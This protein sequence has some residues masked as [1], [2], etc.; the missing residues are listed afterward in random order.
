MESFKSPLHQ[1]VAT[2][3]TD[4]WNDSCSVKELT[5]AMEHGAVGATTNPTIVH[6]V[7]GHEMHLWEE[8]IAEMIAEHPGWSEVELTWK[9]I[10]EMAVR[11][12]E[13]L[14]PVFQREGGKKGRISIQTNPANYRDARSMADQAVHF[15]GLAPNMQVK[16]PATR[17]GV[18]AVEE[19]TFRGVN[20]NATVC[21]TVPQAL[22]VGAA[23]E[24]ALERREA[25]GE[26]TAGMTPVCTIMVGRLDDWLKVVCQRDQVTMT[27]G[28]LDWA[29][30]ACIKQA[31]RL[32][33][34]RGYRTR[35]LAAAYRHHLHWTELIGGDLILTIPYGW[36]RLFNASDMDV[37]PRF[38]DP[39]APDI[40]ARLNRLEDF[41]RA[42]AEDGLSPDEFDTYGGTVRTLRT[43]IASYH[44]LIGVVRDCML[45]DPD[46]M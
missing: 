11:G 39:V 45:P 15:H 33:E 34:E 5:Y 10:E 6:E 38:D 3:A 26:D 7:L 32:F 40:L 41:R 25:A 23:V 27:P 35:L 21:F 31:A 44:D 24:R 18:E 36:Q 43:F 12:A 14:A 4:F 30:V 37:R 42:M 1:T 13:L 19:A 16:I 22:A 2:T 9:L 28:H 20:V 8:R 17:A 29:G 46:R